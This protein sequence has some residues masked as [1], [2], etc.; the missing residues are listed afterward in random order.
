M[1]WGIIPSWTREKRPLINAR[2][3]TVREK[4]SF[5][6]SFMRRRCLLPADGFYEWTKIGK[7]P[8]LF[9]LNNDDPFA[10][11]SFWETVEQIPRCC[12][13]TTSANSLLEPIHD[14]MPVIVRRE[15]WPEWFSSKELADESFQRITAP[16]RP[17]EMSALAVSSLVNSAKFDDP[18]C[19]EPLPPTFGI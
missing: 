13:L 19:C 10:L 1:P 9:A 15:D 5:K 4:G 7:R 11:A 14:R 12:L 8:H 17:E 2:A 3:E 18:R 6:E 16:Y